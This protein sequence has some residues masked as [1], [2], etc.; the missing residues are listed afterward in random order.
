LL[1]EDA[2]D[3]DAGLA[4]VAEASGDATVSCV[5][6]IGVAVDDDGGVASELEDDFFL[7]GAALDI[8]A[9]WDAAGE[10]DELDAVVGDE[11]AG[12]LIGKGGGR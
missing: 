7:P 6:Q 12:V 9:D 8:P 11:Q 10:A 4:G 3:G 2:L 1:D 5:A